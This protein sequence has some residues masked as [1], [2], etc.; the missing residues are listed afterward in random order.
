VKK[1]L[2]IDRCGALRQGDILMSINGRDLSVMS[3]L[4][5][6]E[7]LKQCPIDESAVLM[8]KRKKRFRS[9]TPVTLQSSWDNDNYL[10]PVRNCKTPNAEMMVRMRDT[11]NDF[12][13][14][15]YMSQYIPNSN[16]YATDSFVTHHNNNIKVCF[17][18]SSFLNSTKF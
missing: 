12:I 14:D 3:H 13:S 18:L 11:N 1:I 2:D 10:P 4:D 17:K 15:H 5:V 16:L 7:A 9:K 6:V 8:V